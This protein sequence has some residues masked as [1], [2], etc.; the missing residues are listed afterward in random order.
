M[1]TRA[2]VIFDHTEKLI[3]KT[4]LTFEAFAT[5]VVELY[6]QSVAPGDRGITFHANGDAYKDQRAN[7]QMI[8]RFMVGEARL[9]VELEEAWVLSFP[10]GWRD[11]LLS[12]L[13][14]RMGFMAV[15]VF[16]DNGM[17]QM[18]IT[19]GRWSVEFG[20]ALQAVSEIGSP[21][22]AVKA[23]QEVDD[24]L[25]FGVAMRSAITQ[26]HPGLVE[27]VKGDSWH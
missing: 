23:L 7:A 24:V 22:Q 27:V 16:E 10:D 9:P 5:G 14:R 6:H 13:A 19:I 20:E 21:D 12:V 15:P 11:R 26:R 4:P 2:Q 3:F 17:V 18:M 25:S 1:D 8:R